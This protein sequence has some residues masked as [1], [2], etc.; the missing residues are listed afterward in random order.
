MPSDM[1]R[2][3]DARTADK[4][5]GL[6]HVDHEVEE[7]AQRRRLGGGHKHGRHDLL[8][9]V[10]L[11]VRH[12]LRPR[13]ELLRLG[14]DKVV[15]HRALAGDLDRRPRLLEPLVEVAAVVDAV[16]GAQ[17]AAKRPN[18]GKHKVHLEHALFRLV[19]DIFGLEA[20]LQDVD[21]RGD[22]VHG[23]ERRD[24]AVRLLH[25]K[26]CV[27]DVLVKELSEPLAHDR[28][29]L[30][31]GALRIRL[32][33]AVG[34]RDGHVAPL[35]ALGDVQDAGARRGRGRRKLEVADLK[36]ELHVRQ[37]ADALVGRQR[38]QAVVVHDRVHR[39]DPVGVEVAVEHDPLGVVVRH[40]GELA[41]VERQQAVLPL[42]RRHIDVPIQLLRGD[43]LGVD[44][45]DDDLL[46][47]DHLEVVV[48]GVVGAGGQ[49]LGEHAVALGA[50]RAGWAHEEDA[51]ADGEQLR[52]LHHAQ[53]EVCLR[54]QSHVA[55]RLHNHVLKV[56]VALARRVDAWEKV[57]QQAHEDDHVLGQDL[58]DVEVAQSTEQHVR[59]HLARLGAQ[60]RTGDDQHR[61]DRA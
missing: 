10:I 8:L 30:P 36:D 56:H 37:Q 23:A 2:L 60:Q 41:H 4:H 43:G 44:V 1:L 32:D 33:D 6:P 35:L 12:Q 20:A 59:L 58:G 13:L 48:G 3:A 46:A 26:D 14:V 28:R 11:H 22:E 55:R 61:L 49:R 42:A 53:D 31:L 50:A 54:L 19:V 9:R 40:V 47:V 15:I 16:L 17:A 27:R 5:D 25:L 34:P 38:E 18:H 51:V 7:E 24:V 21:E 39:L 45:A 29:V 57:V 52:E